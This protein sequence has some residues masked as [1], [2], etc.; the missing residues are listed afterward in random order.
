MKIEYKVQRNTRMQSYKGRFN[1]EVFLDG[2]FAFDAQGDSAR[3]AKA[4]AERK[5]KNWQA[6]NA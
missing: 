6:R 4:G 3:E 2:S 1:C 5:V